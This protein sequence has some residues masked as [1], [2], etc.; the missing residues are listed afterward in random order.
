LSLFE[1]SNTA[2]SLDQWSAQAP[3]MINDVHGRSKALPHIHYQSQ[4]VP[5]PLVGVI[6]PW[7][8]PLTLS[9]IDVIPALLAGCSVIVKPSEITPR[10]AAPLVKTIEA[11]PELNNV[12]R[13]ITGAG[14]TGSA[15]IDV[16][17]IVCFTGS[18]AT[19]R[20][21][22]AQAARNFIPVFLELGGKDPLIILKDADLDNAVT[23]ALSGSVINAGQ[24]CQ[25]I[26]RIYVHKSI[27]EDFTAR[28]TQAAS[29]TAL[30]TPDLHKGAIGP[31]IFARQ[32]DIIRA[33]IEDAVK[34]G[35]VIRTGGEIENHGGLWCQPTVLTNVTHDMDIM[36]AET[37]GPLM[38]VM[39]FDTRQEVIDLANDTDFGLSASIIGASA[40]EALDIGRKINAV[41]I[42]ISDAS[43]TT[44]FRDAE[45]CAF[46]FSGMGGSRMGPTALKRF[47]RR[48]ALIINTQN[49]VP[50][51]LF[52]ESN[53]P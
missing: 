51:S 20:K 49:P 11:V 7:N 46:K 10:F 3:H 5:Y 41:A 39:G 13:F 16:S 4:D 37:F 34:K 19:G 14:E 38:P 26:E 21:V 1:V 33:Q 40:D 47:M 6:S 18:V 25:S 2:G 9:V 28:L 15:L 35:A 30:N 12:L 17:D 48:K 27:F 32:A 31:L 43:L 45:K 36:R 22:G 23:A 50:I 44:V 8:F 53:A 24:A 42:S 52:D 29:E